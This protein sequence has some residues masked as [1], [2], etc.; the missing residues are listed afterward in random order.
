MQLT[1]NIIISVS[2]FALAAAGISLIQ[3][4]TRQI[5][6]ILAATMSIAA[7]VCHGMQ[8]IGCP[9]SA[10]AVLAVAIGAVFCCAF[11]WSIMR[12]LGT[13]T[14][15][16]WVAIAVSLGAYLCVQAAL[17]IF[18]G[19]AGRAFP[20]SHESH[21]IGRGRATTVQVMLTVICALAIGGL[22]LLLGFTR[23]GRAIRGLASNADLCVLMGIRT[24]FVRSVAVGVGGALTGIAAILTAADSG[25]VPSTGFTLFLSGVTAAILGGV[26][27]AWG[28]AAGALLLASARHAVAYYGDPKWMDV[29]S[30]LI[31]IGFLIWKPLGFSGR[32]L[33]KVEI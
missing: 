23:I 11:D 21:Q 9:F 4:T 15:A 2:L 10:A 30:F 14:Q 12:S 33:R 16:A 32:R 26:G 13:S 18:F 6:F 29:A 28:V 3:S 7:Y 27:N 8:S 31:L 19:E 5:P 20:L 25:L 17:A 22:L 1:I 24:S